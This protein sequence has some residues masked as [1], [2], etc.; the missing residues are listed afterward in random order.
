MRRILS[1]FIAG[2][3][4]NMK[5]YSKETD[6]ELVSMLKAGDES[7]LS[8]LYL[9]YWDKLLV[10][11]ANRMDNPA[12]AEEVVQDIFFSLW[13]RRESL[14]LKYSLS[15]YLSVAVKYRIIN[16]M[17]KQYRLRNKV[18]KA[19]D[20]RLESCAP[21]AETLMLEKELMAQIATTVQHLPEKCRIV[22]TLSREQGM[23]HKQIAKELNISEKTVEAHLSKAMKDIRSNLTMVF[24]AL[25]WLLGSK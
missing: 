10:V 11:A 24:P 2:K 22:F 4:A 13:Q 18:N 8:A 25:L 17:D 15:T 7:A 20:L 23:S 21:S 19:T 12:E 9:R 16:V 3:N 5:D 14:E 6:Q 1:S